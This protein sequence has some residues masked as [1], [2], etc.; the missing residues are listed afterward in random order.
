METIILYTCYIYSHKFN[1]DEKLLTGRGTDISVMLHDDETQVVLIDIL[2][3]TQL[4]KQ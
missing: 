4:S 3:N 1:L 2:M